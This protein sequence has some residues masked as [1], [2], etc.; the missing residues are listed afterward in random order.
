M[1]GF[2]LKNPA[3]KK[4]RV[5]NKVIIQLILIGVTLTVLFPLLVIIS[6]AFKNE[7]EIFDF[8]MSII[9][10]NIIL[11]NFKQLLV[12]FPLY[13]F[14]SVKVTLLIVI[15]Q[16]FTA[17]TGA[18]AFAKLKWKG[19]EVLFLIYI[20]SMMIP[21][22]VQI[23]P[24]FIIIRNMGLYDTH[25]S[26]ILLGSFSAFGTFLVK[27]YF[28]TIPDSFIEA[29]KIDGA[30]DFYIFYKIMLP[31]AKPALA[32]QVIFSFRYFWNDFFTPMIFITSDHL[33]TIPLGIANF[34]REYVTYYG[35]K[36]AACLLSIIP[37]MIIFFAA[38]SHFVEGVSSSGLKG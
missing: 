20:C 4:Q 14:N 37:V 11:D 32:A 30:H 7:G 3:R 34:T 17:T 15:I 6:S 24:Q 33:K 28:M 9:P 8:P 23:I 19:R 27:Q 18:Y 35:P 22:Q 5:V 26:L 36:M 10:Q 16:M 2:V 25:L 13:I 21:V 12:S 31:L 1:R 38:Q 29:A